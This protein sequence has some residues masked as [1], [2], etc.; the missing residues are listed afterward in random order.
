MALYMDVHD[1]LPDGTTA[2]D[3]AGAHAADLRVQERFGARYLNYWVDEQDSKVFCL[4]DGRTLTPRTRCTARRWPGRRRDL[5]RR[6]GVSGH[7]VGAGASD[8][9]RSPGRH[10]FDAGTMGCADGLAREFR[11]SDPAHPARRRALG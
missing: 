6:A 5:P 11:E 2:A 9:D 4:I 3:V 8:T 7:D 10:R 1:S